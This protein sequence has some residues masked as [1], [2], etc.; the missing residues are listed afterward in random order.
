MD[1]LCIFR[2]NCKQQKKRRRGKKKR[3]KT[4]GRYQATYKAIARQT[5]KNQKT[6]RIE[7]ESLTQGLSKVDN[8]F[9]ECITHRSWAFELN[10]M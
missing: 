5:V 9:L 1:N 2:Y 8:R 10:F 7:L 3:K 4:K 6:Q